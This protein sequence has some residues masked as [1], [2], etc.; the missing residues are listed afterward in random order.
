M[1][2][3]AE[4]SPRARR[5]E[6]AAKAAT[7]RARRAPAAGSTKSVA[8]TKKKGV[9]TR[10]RL[11]AAART[12]FVQRGFAGARVERIL[13]KAKA[14]PR[15]LYHHFGG[16]AEIYV[17]VLEDALAGLRRHELALDVARADPLDGLLRLFD[18]LNDYFETNPTL[19]RLL[20]N[21][22]LEKARFMKNSA[23]IREMS[24]P[25]L[26]MIGRFLERGFAEGQIARSLD[27]LRVYTLMVALAQFHVSNVHTLSVIF[28]TDLAAKAWRATRKA[29]ARLMIASF[30]R[31]KAI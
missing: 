24:S 21:E 14:N 3:A 6:P 10:D 4:R 26:D 20:T 12:E 19:V 16:K 28:E 30:L 31:E 2:A 27:P 29:D 25:V 13:V 23:R 22:N 17:A 18:F 9:P 7:P 11:L 5:G 1:R 8:E 15:M